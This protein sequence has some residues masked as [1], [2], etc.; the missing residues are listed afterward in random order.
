MNAFLLK[1]FAADR[2]FY[3]GGCNSLV[4][5]TVDGLYGILAGHEKMVIAVSPGRAEFSD[6]NGEKVEAVLSPGICKIDTDG[7]LI[8]VETAERPEEIETRRAEQEAKDAAEAQRGRRNVSDVKR[9]KAKMARNAS[10][11]GAKERE[12]ID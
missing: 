6:Q 2:V 10:R 12:D 4:I 11:L 9:A 3:Q 1:I 8:M 5:P 7:V